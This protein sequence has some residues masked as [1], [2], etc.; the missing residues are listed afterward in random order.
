MQL[1]SIQVPLGRLASVT[2]TERTD[3]KIVYDTQIKD[4]VLR[5]FGPAVPLPFSIWSQLGVSAP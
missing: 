3:S 1:A 5:A 2:M 4:M